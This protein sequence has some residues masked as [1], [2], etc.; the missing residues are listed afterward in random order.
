M[1]PTEDKMCSEKNESHLFLLFSEDL[2]EPLDC[3]VSLQ[4][5]FLLRAEFI[6]LLIQLH[7]QVLLA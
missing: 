1:I 5:I 7:Q 3:F 6:L 2:S 4:S